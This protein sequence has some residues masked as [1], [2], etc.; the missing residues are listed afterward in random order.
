MSASVGKRPPSVPGHSGPTKLSSRRNFAPLSQD[1]NLA[2]QVSD[3]CMSRSINIRR[4]SVESGDPPTPPPLLCRQV[5]RGDSER[6]SV[7]RN[8]HTN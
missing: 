5:W 4:C 2:C 1:M 8:Q 3:F 7:D 6:N